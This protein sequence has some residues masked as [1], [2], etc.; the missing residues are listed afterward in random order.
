[1][2]ILKI[3][4]TNCTPCKFVGSFLDA[5]GVDYD[6]LNIA[7]ETVID[8]YNIMSVPVTILLDENNNEIKR[9]VGFNPSELEE[10]VTQVK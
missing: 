3:E 10:I 1:M 8:K 7:N 2:K 5:K 4:K 6:V 9:S